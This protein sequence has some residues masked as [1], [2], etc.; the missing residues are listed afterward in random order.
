MQLKAWKCK[1]CGHNE[2]IQPG[3]DLKE[4]GFKWLGPLTSFVN[5]P[6]CKSYTIQR[7]YDD[8]FLAGNF[9][10]V[11]TKNSIKGKG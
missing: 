4:L 2:P 10:V 9:L 1:N 5:C 7:A 6:A 8:R 3:N 11:V